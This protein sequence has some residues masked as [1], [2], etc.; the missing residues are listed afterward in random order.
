MAP[1][2]LLSCLCTFMVNNV[3]LS[4]VFGKIFLKS[5]TTCE[6]LRK[7]PVCVA[8]LKYS[9]VCYY[10]SIMT[11]VTRL[12]NIN[13]TGMLKKAYFSKHSEG[14]TVVVKLMK[15]LYVQC[16]F[17][18]GYDV[19]EYGQSEVF[20]NAFIQCPAGHTCMLKKDGGLGKCCKNGPG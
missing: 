3:C 14:S 13:I 20:C 8:S 15:Y 17:I 4:Q 18:V 19:C 10:T 2:C 11:I 1:L 6:I 12:P 16:N 9:I 7:E 5:N